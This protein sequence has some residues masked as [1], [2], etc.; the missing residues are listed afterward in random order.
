MTL[1]PVLLNLRIC[2][3][4]FFILPSFGNLLRRSISF[5]FQRVSY[6][7]SL[8]RFLMTSTSLNPLKAPRSPFLLSVLLTSGMHLKAV[9]PHIFCAHSPILLYALHRMLTTKIHSSNY[10]IETINIPAI[11]GVYTII[12]D[13]ANVYAQGIFIVQ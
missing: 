13:S 8:S 6:I 4:Y 3:Q 5:C 2:F 7:G 10:S 11:S 12:I 9:H 1:Y